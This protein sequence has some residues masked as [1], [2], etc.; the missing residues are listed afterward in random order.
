MLLFCREIESIFEEETILITLN[1]LKNPR[2]MLPV[3]SLIFVYENEKKNQ[4]Y[5]HTHKNARRRLSSYYYTK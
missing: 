5:V 3:F 2:L 4:A 1:R